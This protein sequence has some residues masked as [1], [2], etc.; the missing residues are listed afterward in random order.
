MFSLQLPY[1]PHIMYCSFGQHP[2]N[3]PPIV[4][5]YRVK[6]RAYPCLALGWSVALFLS[7]SMPV[8]VH[9]HTV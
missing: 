1:S 4:A 2:F 6:L 3:K 5:Y 9:H 7:T 8:D